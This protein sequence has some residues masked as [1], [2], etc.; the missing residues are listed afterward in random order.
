MQDLENSGN[1]TTKR[2]VK[3][4]HN[5]PDYTGDR[6]AAMLLV[7]KLQNYY[8]ERGYKDI[9]FWLEPQL[10]GSG[11]RIWGTRSNIVFN[12]ASLGVS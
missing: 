2:Q 5:I 6:S 12:V 9:H 4:L 1:A 11:K 3:S 8:K 10:T 7:E